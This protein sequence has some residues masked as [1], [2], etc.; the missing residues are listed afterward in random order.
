MGRGG[1]EA[2]C[3]HVAQRGREGDTFLCCRHFVDAWSGCGEAGG[4][5]LKFLLFHT[6]VHLT[7][8]KIR[9]TDADVWSVWIYR[10]GL[11]STYRRNTDS[12]RQVSLPWKRKTWLF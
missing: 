6:S 3:S 9:G 2:S 5:F 10:E 4:V 1:T 11:L 12:S 8:E 7:E